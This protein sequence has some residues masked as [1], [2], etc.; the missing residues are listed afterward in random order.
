MILFNIYNI[1]F[2]IVMI[3]FYKGVGIS[4]RFKDRISLDTPKPCY[5]KVNC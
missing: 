3:S 5:E 1:H 2:Q 4:A